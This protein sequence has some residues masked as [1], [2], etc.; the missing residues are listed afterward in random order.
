MWQVLKKSCWILFR[1]LLRSTDETDEILNFTF[2][3]GILSCRRDRLRRTSGIF[4]FYVF[5]LAVFVY[6]SY[7]SHLALTSLVIFAELCI[8]FVMKSM[9]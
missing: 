8:F 4:Q 6:I 7:L 2:S 5:L 1:A 3:T 9:Y